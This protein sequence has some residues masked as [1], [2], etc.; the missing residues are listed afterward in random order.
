[1]QKNTNTVLTVKTVYSEN[2]LN[3]KEIIEE[4]ILDFIVKE[5]LK[6]SNQ[7]IDLSIPKN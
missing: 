5:A 2:S 7:P 1:M 6:D 3:I 4:T